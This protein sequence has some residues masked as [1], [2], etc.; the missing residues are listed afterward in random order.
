GIDLKDIYIVP[1]L[2]LVSDNSSLEALFIQ[3]ATAY[4][5]PY[6]SLG[7]GKS[8]LRT[9][10]PDAS[11]GVVAEAGFKFRL[12]VDWPWRILGA[13]YEFAGIRMGVRTSGLNHLDDL[14]FITEFGAGLW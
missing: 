3:S 1:K 9:G 14:R 12:A 6:L 11:S 8:S 4:A 5:S 7:Y 13:G 2:N 10:Q